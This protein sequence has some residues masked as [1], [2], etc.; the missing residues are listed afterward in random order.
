[1]K[2]HQPTSQRRSQREWSTTTGPQRGSTPFPNALLDF[3]MPRLKDTEWRV[4][5]VVVRQTMGWQS[6]VTG[7]R[8]TCDWLT[9]AQLKRRTGRHSAA[10]SSAIRGLVALKLIEVRDASGELVSSPKARR[11]MRG[12]LFFSLRGSLAK[13]EVQKANTTKRNSYKKERRGTTSLRPV[14]EILRSQPD[15]PLPQE[16]N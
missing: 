15:T 3:W 1:M 7:Q 13:S 12:R 2:N 8:K 4:L 5:S 16:K 10:L 9:Q 14:G 11:L 6:P